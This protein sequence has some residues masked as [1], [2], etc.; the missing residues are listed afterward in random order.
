MFKRLII[1][2]A[3][4]AVLTVGIP[5]KEE[6]YM[7]A[8]TKDYKAEDI[9]NMSKTEIRSTIDYVFE[10]FDETKEEDLR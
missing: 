6:M 7:M 1:G 2:I 4:S 3:I 10:K 5:G 8:L 9:Y